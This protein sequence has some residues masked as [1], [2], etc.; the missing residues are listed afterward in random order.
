MAWPG[1]QV[2]IRISFSRP[3]LP[4]SLAK[5]FS[6]SP[7]FRQEYDS[8]ARP[9]S[10]RVVWGDGQTP[11]QV[12]P[13]PRGGT[14]V[15]R[16]WWLDVGKPVAIASIWSI[17]PNALGVFCDRWQMQRP[18][19]RIEQLLNLCCGSS[20][21]GNGYHRKTPSPMAIA[22]TPAKQN[23]PFTDD[24]GVARRS[25]ALHCADSTNHSPW[26]R[27]VRAD[28]HGCWAAFAVAD[29]RSPARALSASNVRHPNIDIHSRRGETANCC[30]FRFF[31]RH[32][33]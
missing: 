16:F 21:G 12:V 3:V 31:F 18:L 17:P 15:A 29:C 22:A 5:S 10:L 7:G 4:P 20:A 8:K 13:L 24:S 2:L 27:Q 32:V 9:T 25:F 14:V 28:R 30:F 1:K 11:S 23:G 6:A 19:R 26:Y 33:V